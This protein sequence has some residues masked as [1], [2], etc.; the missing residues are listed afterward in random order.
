MQLPDAVRECF[1]RYVT[2]F[3]VPQGSPGEAFEETARQWTIRFAEQVAFELPGQGWGM[4][5]ADPNRPIS[6]DTI[7]RLE[8]ERMFIWDLLVG[9]GTGAPRATENPQGEE[10]HDQVFVPVTPT[11]HLLVPPPPPPPESSSTTTPGRKKTPSVSNGGLETAA[12]VEH[13]A[14]IRKTLEA[15]LKEQEETRAMLKALAERVP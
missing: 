9:T 6:K 11:N 5:R 2:A 12:A 4:K 1:T 15:I 3:P 7:T 14:A 8:G 13:L 10:I